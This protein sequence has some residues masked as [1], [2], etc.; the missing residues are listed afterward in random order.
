MQRFFFFQAEDGIRDLTV[1]GV[2]TCALPI[3]DDVYIGSAV[4]ARMDL[5]DINNVQVLRGPQG[6]LFGRNTI[7][8]A[9]LMSTADPGDRFGG[10]VRGGFGSDKLFDGFLA[11]N[12]PL[13]DA[14]KA[15]FTAGR[16]KQ[17]GYVTRTDGTDLGDTDT[18]TLTSKFIWKP[19]EKLEARWLADYSHA[20][21]HGSPLVFASINTAATFPR[22]ASA[23]AGCP[24]FNG[25]FRTLPAV[26]NIPDDRCANN[27]QNR[28]PFHNNGTT[29]LTSELEGWGSSLNVAYNFTDFTAL[30][31]IT[32]YR[33]EEH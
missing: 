4:G 1:T 25:N 28:G 16:R 5:R 29:P 31:F 6:T 19:T 17:D 24:G 27:F 10:A 20:D 7:G 15:R 8:G 21:E 2:Q 30:K 26:P 11:L 32:A 22:V 9:I 23:A 18:Y 13:S 14:L 3:F 12:A 33:S